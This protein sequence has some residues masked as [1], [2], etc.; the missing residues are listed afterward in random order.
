MTQL[1]VC[2]RYGLPPGER[3]M[4]GIDRMREVYGIR[5]VSFDEAERTVRVEY[6]ATRLTD[7]IVASLL[8]NAGIDLKQRIALV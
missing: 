8:K 6:D 2:Y 1:D 4:A 7:E 3:A 5:R